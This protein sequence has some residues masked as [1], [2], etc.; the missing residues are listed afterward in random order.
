MTQTNIIEKLEPLAIEWREKHI[1]I[2]KIES[3]KWLLDL[4]DKVKPKKILEL[5]TAVGYSGTILGS[6]GG[7]LITIDSDENALKTAESTFEKFGT[8]VQIIHSDASEALKD[9]VQLG[10]FGESFDFIFIDHAKAKYQE[11]YDWCL[12]LSSRGTIIVID[13]I[14]NKKCANFLLSV[15]KDPRIDFEMIEINDGFGY[16]VVK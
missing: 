5:G 10:L 16:I 15:Q 3:A 8:N 4:V 2:L 7:E 12:K 11:A 9:M 13:N 1:P 6:T 14:K